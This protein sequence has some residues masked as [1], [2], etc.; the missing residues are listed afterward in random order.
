MISTSFSLIQNI[1]TRCLEWSLSFLIGFPAQT[2]QP[3][4][5]GNMSESHQHDWVTQGQML[6]DQRFMLKA[7]VSNV[8]G[9]K[10]DAGNL[11]AAP[12]VTHGHLGPVPL[13]WS[14]Y[15]IQ[16]QH[17]QSWQKLFQ[18][19]ETVCLL[20]CHTGCWQSESNKIQEIFTFTCY[21]EEL[22]RWKDIS[23]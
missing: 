12:P 21:C 22:G 2:E 5:A 16:H 17:T 14:C 1:A 20:T 4:L 10:K 6:L 15:S 7:A 23:V 8:H 19:L 18:D 9:G 13:N 11:C 3:L